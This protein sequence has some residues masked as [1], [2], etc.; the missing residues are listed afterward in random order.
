MVLASDLAGRIAGHFRFHGM[1]DN[2][3]H[4]KDKSRLYVQGFDFDFNV[5]NKELDL[6]IFTPSGREEDF[7]KYIPKMPEVLKD[8]RYSSI[9]RKQK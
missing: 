5:K 3:K 2:V 4:E 9:K 8:D 6:S 7:Q 1:R